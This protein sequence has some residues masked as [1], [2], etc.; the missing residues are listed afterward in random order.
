MS[1]D[2][3]WQRNRS[4]QLPC[5]FISTDLNRAEHLDLST[6]FRR[7]QDSGQGS[8][9]LHGAAVGVSPQFR[10]SLCRAYEP[11]APVCEDPVARGQKTWLCFSPP[12]LAE[13]YHQ[14]LPREI[15]CVGLLL[16]FDCV[17]I[18]ESPHEFPRARLVFRDEPKPL[19]HRSLRG[20]PG[21]PDPARHLG[22][23]NCR[24]GCAGGP[25]GRFVPVSCTAALGKPQINNP[26]VKFCL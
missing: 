14:L 11:V 5:R 16:H 26:Q 12:T 1:G 8:P 15:S 4:K 25:A 20:F 24:V 13:R 7:L 10:V 17:F 9:D 22:M 6:F 2:A 3:G 19:E 23:T 21:V 18:Q